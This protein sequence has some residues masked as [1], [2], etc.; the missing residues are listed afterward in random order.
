MGLL[1]NLRIGL[2]ALFRRNVVDRDIDDEVH[3]YLEREREAHEAAGLSPDAAARAARVSMGS[4]TAVHDR[5]Q[6]AG[7][8]AAVAVFGRDLRYGA[9]LL[10]RTP[11]FTAIAILTL[12]L[13]IGANTALFSVADEVLLKPL[14]VADPGQLVYFS[15]TAAPKGMPRISVA[16]VAQD[17]LTGQ[18]RSTAFSKLTFDRFRGE[19][20]SL[21]GVFAF[22]AAVGVTQPGESTAPA[23]QLVSGNYFAVLG[24]Q[25]RLG[26]LLTLDDDR[27]SAPLV[28]VISHR[29]WGRTFGADPTVVGRTMRFESGVATIVGVTP[30][31]F[32]GTGQLG[33]APDFFL[34]MAT[35]AAVSRNKFAVRMKESW[36]WPLRIFG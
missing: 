16:G 36:I 5:V 21:G 31:G 19:T 8:E 2:R 27:D 1:R 34:P 11:G 23:G 24:T 4:V 25:P 20:T 15:W 22:G 26:R 6:D 29:Y 28:V 18:A 30:A 12:A 13:G 7:W 35:G 3:D 10:A 33:D 14:P 17:P 9:R 32:S